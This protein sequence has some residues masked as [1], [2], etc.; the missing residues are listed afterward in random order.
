MTVTS[1]DAYRNVSLVHTPKVP[2]IFC[3]RFVLFQ[4]E[5]CLS[6]C[7]PCPE[8]TLTGCQLLELRI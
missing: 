3:F 7:S 5:L 4:D 8:A 1:R 6:V 2:L